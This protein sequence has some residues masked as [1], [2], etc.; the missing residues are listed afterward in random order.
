MHAAPTTRV[1]LASAS[2]RR[3]EMLERLGVTFRRLPQEI[4][5]RVLPDEDPE[6]YA[7]RVAKAKARAAM[8]LLDADREDAMEVVLAADTVVVVGEKILGKPSS[9]SEAKKMIRALSGRDHHVVTGWWLLR[10]DGLCHQG[11]ART[12]VRFRV[13]REEEVEGYLDLNQ[14]QDKAGSYGIQDAAAFM[15]EEVEGSYTNVV[16]LPLSQVTEALWETGAVRRLPSS[17]H[18]AQEEGNG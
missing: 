14:W 17:R 4:D 18:T 1:V 11:T 9:R 5:E 6:T 7:L 2:P 12:R 8:A 15:V 16:G 10:T 13:L 3:A